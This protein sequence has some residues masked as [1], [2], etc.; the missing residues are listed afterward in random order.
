MRT[1]IVSIRGGRGKEIGARMKISILRFNF[2]ENIKDNVDI[3]YIS[4]KHVSKN[5]KFSNE[6]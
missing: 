6:N 4:R 3:K 2:M 1:Y 5:M